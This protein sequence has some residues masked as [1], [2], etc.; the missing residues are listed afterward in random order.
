MNREQ[1]VAAVI[2]RL[3][4]LETDEERGMFADDAGRKFDEGW[5]LED[6]VRYLRWTE[7]VNPGI[8][9]ARALA[10]MAEIASKY[11]RVNL[12]PTVRGILGRE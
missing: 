8:P 10:R 6:T 1:Y 9:E 5:A 7:H 11:D 2:A 12:G 4:E 3:P